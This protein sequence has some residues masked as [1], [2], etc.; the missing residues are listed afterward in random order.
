MTQEIDGYAV[1]E[2]L[3]L[4]RNAALDAMAMSAAQCVTLTAR[5]AALEKELTTRPPERPY[6]PYS[7]HPVDA[8]PL[9]LV[10]ETP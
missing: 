3:K 6:D 9:K 4:Q 10:N 1:V 2:Q 7:S 8:P 5:V